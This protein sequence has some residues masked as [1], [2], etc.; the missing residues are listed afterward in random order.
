MLELLYKLGWPTEKTIIH[1]PAYLFTGNLYRVGYYGEEA[2][3]LISLLYYENCLTIPRK[4]QKAKEAINNRKT[5]HG[6]NTDSTSTI[7]C[8][9]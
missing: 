1:H 9:R 2:I 4:L 5:N 3:K 7:N 6:T 8:S